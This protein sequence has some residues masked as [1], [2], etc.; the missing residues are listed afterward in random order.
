MVDLLKLGFVLEHLILLGGTE[1][2]VVVA[3]V[4]EIAEQ[5]AKMHFAFDNLLAR[6]DFGFVF[7]DPVPL[8]L[9]AAFIVDLEEPGPQVLLGVGSA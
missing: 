1:R 6:A 5:S 3:S 8:G 4:V 7:L 2:A 9:H